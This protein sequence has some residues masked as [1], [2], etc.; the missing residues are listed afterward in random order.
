MT[1]LLL[2]LM[3]RLG[4]VAQWHQRLLLLLLLLLHGIIVLGSISVVCV[5][6]TLRT[7]ARQAQRAQMALCTIEGLTNQHC[8]VQVRKIYLIGAND[9]SPRRQRLQ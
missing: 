2:R 5:V 4:F 9:W 6:I 8:H 7:H 1:N 3:I